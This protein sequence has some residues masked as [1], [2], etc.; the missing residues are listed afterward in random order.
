MYHVFRSHDT[1]FAPS[2][3]HPLSCRN[4]VCTEERVWAAC[5]DKE[6]LPRVH[7]FTEVDLESEPVTRAPEFPKEMFGVKASEVQQTID[8]RRILKGVTPSW[9]HAG[10]S[11]WHLPAVDLI[12]QDEVLDTQGLP[13]E[14]LGKAWWCNL[15]PSGCQVALKRVGPVLNMTW[16]M[17]VT[18]LASQ[19]LLTWKMRCET[20]SL[21]AHLVPVFTP[22]DLKSFHPVEVTNPREWDAV[23]VEIVSP[24]AARYEMA[25]KDIPVDEY[26]HQMI[27]RIRVVM[28]VRVFIQDAY[29]I[30]PTPSYDVLWVE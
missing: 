28:K 17:V 27:N 9:Y 26:T 10:A 14:R 2:K 21:G 13:M 7:N 15:I 30:P 18:N 12:L 8:L 25:K 1:F 4:D 19:M 11:K 20:D 24:M 6:L 23:F 29:A 3:S 16:Y 22:D 5:V